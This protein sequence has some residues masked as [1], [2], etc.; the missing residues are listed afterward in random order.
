MTVEDQLEPEAF[1]SYHHG[2]KT[3]AGRINV[4]EVLTLHIKGQ[5]A[6]RLVKRAKSNG[7]TVEEEAEA[8]LEEALKTERITKPQTGKELLK[9]LRETGVVGMWKDRTDIGDSVEFPREL[10]RKAQCRGKEK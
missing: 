2:M 9:A 5:V 1:L 3:T 4:L 6:S 10:R 7:S 8:L